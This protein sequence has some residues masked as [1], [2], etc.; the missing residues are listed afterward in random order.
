MDTI[1]F[2]Q[3]RTKRLV[4]V[5]ILF[6]IVLLVGAF[7]VVFATHAASAANTQRSVHLQGQASWS[8]IGKVWTLTVTFVPLSGDFHGSRQ[9]QTERSLMTFLPSGG[10]TATFPGSTPDAPPLQPPAMSGSW[11]MGGANAFG[12]QF[13]EPLLAS[14]KMVAYVQVRIHASLISPTAFVAG[15]IGVAYSLATGLPIPGQYN[16]SSTTAV[17]A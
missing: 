12:Y 9:G 15:G 2:E 11:T 4:R 14:G 13:Q 1:S 10:L 6:L 3:K 5:G 7:G 8:P 17:A 16:V